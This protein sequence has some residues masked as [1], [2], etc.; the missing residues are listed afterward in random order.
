MEIKNKIIIITGAT[1]GIGK[2]TAIELAKK[3]AQ[4]ILPVRNSEKGEKVKKEI[5]E[6]S[7]N[8]NVRI[9]TCDLESLDS[10]RHFADSFKKEYKQLDV[11][12][13]NAGVWFSKRE[14]TKEGFE[15]NLGINYLSHFLLTMLLLDIMKNTSNARII[16]LS[17]EAHRFTNINFDDL[18]SEKN[19]NNFKAYGQSKLALI[20]FTKKLHELLK[21]T[22]ITVNCLHPG[23]VSTNLFDKMGWPMKNIFQMF[24]IRPEEGAATSIYLATSDDVKNISGE[25]FKKKKVAKS[26]SFSNRKDAADKLWDI[27]MKLVGLE[28]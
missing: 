22:D 25:Y 27:S 12:I 16:N 14:L 11:L 6:I 5:I 2:V 24:M 13:N 23:V 17:S 15:K 1:S 19:F 26:T 28:R 20:L 18:Q 4:L 3:G 21:E 9:M 10:V 7:G 8:N